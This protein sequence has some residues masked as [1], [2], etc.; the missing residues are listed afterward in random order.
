[1]PS[2]ATSAL[3]LVAS[4]ALAS[5]ALA[6]PAAPDLP[7]AGDVDSQLA[8]D[9]TPIP[10]GMGALFVGSASR[11]ELEPMIH[12]YAGDERVATS[13]IGRR[14]PLPPG[15]YAV[16][17][18]QGPIEWRARTEVAIAAG[19]TT[20]APPFFGAVR[21]TA[22]DRFDRTAAARYL[23]ASDDGER[24]Y[25]PERT[26]E[27][28]AYRTT[29]T[30][31]LAP[32]RYHLVHGTDPDQAEGRVAFVVSAGDR[33][34]YRLV[35]DGDR[36]VR[37]E[38]ADRPLEV[39]DAI[40]RLDWVIGGSMS[41]DRATSQLSGFSGEALRLGAFTRLETGIDVGDHL[42]LFQLALDQDWV[43]LEHDFGRGLPFQKLTDL[44]QAEL[45][46]NYRLAEIVGPYVR[47]RVR[48]SFFK[49]EIHPEDDI[50]VD[51]VRADG[52]SDSFEASAG[53]A[54]E[55]MP[56][57]APTILQESVGIGVTLWDDDVFSFIVRGG[58]AARQHLYGDGGRYLSRVASDRIE[59]IE[60]DDVSELGLEVSASLRLR[61]G[62]LINLQS[63]F[64][65]FASFDRTFGD[66]PF[67]PVF[68]WDNT[69]TLRLSTWASLV[70]RLVLHKDDARLEDIQ[71][72]QSLNLRFQYA[73]F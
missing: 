50:T 58:A 19:E 44:A 34:A 70:Y 35:V 16:V 61:L 26:S 2:P 29:R 27:D 10:S 6:A 14:V 39:R 11:P 12:V 22:V 68:F 9:V 17:A 57:L 64:D 73:I 32:G 60:L 54:V 41:F 55:L 48:T 56:S 45:M 8:L 47:A 4:L 51:V 31:L 25:G 30:W 36:L 20:V 67:T 72:R 46:Y 63:S 71:T 38:F 1:M 21:V 40:W 37:T 24:V 28:A 3:A 59:L 15:R 69:V 62:E 53:D 13:A 52:S 23:I 5:S 66:D 65:S 18:G 43:G 49:T 42:A 33:T 7:E